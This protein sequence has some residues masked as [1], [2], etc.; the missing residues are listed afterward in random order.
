MT[1]LEEKKALA[2]GVSFYKTKSEK[3]QARVMD[4]EADMNSMKNRGYDLVNISPS[5]DVKN[6]PE[7]KELIRRTE[8]YVKTAEAEKADLMKKSEVML[9]SMSQLSI[10]KAKISDE[11]VL[12]NSKIEEL[13][14]KIT[15]IMESKV[16]ENKDDSE[17]LLGLKENEGNL[18]LDIEKLRKELDNITAEK[19]KQISIL[20]S[21]T[22]IEIG[23]LTNE[24]MNLSQDSKYKA[25]Y[26]DL[27][28]KFNQ[29]QNE[30]AIAKRSSNMKSVIE[31]DD[32]D[33]MLVTE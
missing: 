22:S 33:S 8:E 25:M 32:D 15:S 21:S 23:N 24:I 20:E 14:D 26:I 13:K 16:G 12:L 29:L 7:F 3:L 17:R 4:L 30:L 9:S 6:S 5:G 19:D 10:E 27:E 31:D 2:K 18:K 1:N 28:V 11:N